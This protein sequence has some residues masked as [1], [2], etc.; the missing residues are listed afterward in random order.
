VDST[1][2][3]LVAD[4]STSV[5]I[6]QPVSQS[7]LIGAVVDAAS[8]SAI[9]LS[10]GKIVVIYGT[11]LGP[12]NLVSNQPQD[13]GFSTQVA[14]TTVSMNGIPAPILY[15]SRTQVAAISPYGISGANAQVQV[16][17]Q[18]AASQVVSLPIAASAP[19]LF[20]FNGSGAG[21][22]AA[23]NGD[24]SINDAAHPVQIGGYLSLYATGEGG[25]TPQGSDGK[26]APLAP[27]FAQPQL[28]VNV[29]VGGLP[30]TVL[31]A[32]AAPG[33]VAGLMQVVIQI[34][35]GAQ[36]DGYVPVTL[37]V[38]AASS[39]AGAAWIAVSNSR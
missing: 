14:G 39:V 8:Q 38:G 29:T 1:G 24:G 36:A 21:Q 9:A 31:Y 34:P 3:I 22:A 5:R 25:T 28:S 19:S 23:V 26:V 20:S 2:R 37:Q 18:G 6:L 17:Y 35:A 4:D 30:A 16:S 12:A 15:T 11:G 10:P 13:G 27:P 33:E 7:I 32:G